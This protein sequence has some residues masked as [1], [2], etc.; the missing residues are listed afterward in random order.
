MITFDT[1]LS[2]TEGLKAIKSYYSETI[3]M[4]DYLINGMYVRYS[5]LNGSN[6]VDR[7]VMDV[8]DNE[9][10]DSWFY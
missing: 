8:W 4:E 5:Y 3:I 10:E 9:V 1:Y 2:D 7:T 6:S